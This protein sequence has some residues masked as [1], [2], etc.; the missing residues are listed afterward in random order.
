MLFGTFVHMTDGDSLSGNFDSI[1]SGMW[2]ALVTL[3]TVGYG[4]YS[5]QTEVEI[6]VA[7]VLMLAGVVF[8][9]FIMSSMNDILTNQGHKIQ[10]EDKSSSL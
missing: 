4:D 5:P 2:F 8:F 10:L 7:I 3:T 1:P 9:S 6:A